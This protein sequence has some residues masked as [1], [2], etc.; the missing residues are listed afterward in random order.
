MF[1]S[2]EKHPKHG[3]VIVDGVVA[4]VSALK[5]VVEDLAGHLQ[6]RHPVISDLFSEDF[7]RDVRSQI[8][9]H[10]GAFSNSCGHETKALRPNSAG[11]VVGAAEIC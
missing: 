6:P 8:R 9:R 11:I 1:D 3:L 7:T 2:K 10:R 4:N 5:V